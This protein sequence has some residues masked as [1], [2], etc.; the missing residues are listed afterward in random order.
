[1]KRQAV[2]LSLG[3][4]SIAG[5][6]ARGQYFALD[7][8]GPPSQQLSTPLSTVSHGV[9]LRS[10]AFLLV[11]RRE[12]AIILAHLTLDTHSQVGRV[13]AGPGEYR[14]PIRALSDGRGGAI[15][16]DEELRRSIRVAANGEIV[17]DG[18]TSHET[19]FSP[20]SI[21]GM[22]PAGRVLHYGP[23]APGIRD[24]L[25]IQRWDPS[26]GRSTLLGWWPT[27]QAALG[28]ATKT[29][30][31]LTSRE[32]MMPSLWPLR[33]TW[34]ALPD[35]AIAIVRPS[36]YQIEIITPE[37]HRSLGPVV[38]YQ[39]VRVTSAHRDAIR[40]ERGPIP[41]DQ[42][43][44]LLPPF[45]GLDDVIG[46]PT[47]EV[48][49]GRMRAWND[50]VPVYDIFDSRG[51]PRGHARLRSRS[52]VVGFGSGAVYVA[53]EDPDDGL[54]FLERYLRRP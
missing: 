9:E 26:T 29:P 6:E 48:W 4:L 17:G 50:T 24:S 32:I 39:P 18:L 36:P 1:M 5:G 53:R 10:G 52:K 12:R 14:R 33:A 28:V 23:V 21:R 15:V 54:W 31:G 34:V 41:D 13:G 11:D 35:G 16:P 30:Q 25:P 27:T 7:L 46:S 22:D 40:Q 45:E 47:G 19:G 38:Q 20:A 3:L 44:P 8:T 43:P 51:V 2:G 37:G 49:V 42:F